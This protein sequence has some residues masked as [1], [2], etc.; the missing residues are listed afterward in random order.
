AA[1]DSNPYGLFLRSELEL[2]QRHSDYYLLHEHLE[3]N[4]LPVYFFQF[5]EQAQAQGLRYLGEADI[6][7]MVP[8]HFPPEVAG[9]LQRL[10]ADLL[11]LEQ[12]MDFLRNRMFRQ[13]L[14]CHADHE[15]RYHLK[16]EC[17][18]DFHV[19]A[20]VRP[21]AP[22]PNLHSTEFEQFDSPTGVTL[23]SRDPI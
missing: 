6:S 14:L 21:T 9:V 10:S 4:N 15:P 20:P 7:V 3:D 19:A 5:I 16:P 23:S 8:G 17:L 1:G 2:L 11:H 22:S 18:V 13:T 12:Y